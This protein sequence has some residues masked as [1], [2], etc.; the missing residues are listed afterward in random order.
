[1]IMFRELLSFNGFMHVQV[2]CV[3]QDPGYQAAPQKLGDAWW[4]VVE[5]PSAQ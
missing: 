3:P 5:F 4:V 2:G 1:M